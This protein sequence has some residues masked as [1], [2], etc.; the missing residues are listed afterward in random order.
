MTY[1]E[2]LLLVVI[3]TTRLASTVQSGQVSGVRYA[4][5]HALGVHAEP[6]HPVGVR[7]LDLVSDAKSCNA[8][9]RSQPSTTDSSFAHCS[10]QASRSTVPAAV[11][12]SAPVA[13]AFSVAPDAASS[14]AQ[15]GGQV[16]SAAAQAQPLASALS[17][18]VDTPERAPSA[19]G[20][21]CPVVPTA[22]ATRKLRHGTRAGQRPSGRLCVLP[23]AGPRGDG[24][25]DPP[26]LHRLADR[27]IACKQ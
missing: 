20:A 16:A 7:Q 14:P 19:S 24:A 8:L 11:P 2:W 9:I 25:K 22:S 13:A 1:T 4:G 10:S 6:L 26:V 5:D 21:P 18:A 17:L 15:S 23:R 3:E 12:P 27:P